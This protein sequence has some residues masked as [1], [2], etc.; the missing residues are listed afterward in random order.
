[1][2]TPSVLMPIVCLI[3]VAALL[4]ISWALG[5]AMTRNL[6]KESTSDF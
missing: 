4:A 3:G 2:E 6:D 1:M 5:K